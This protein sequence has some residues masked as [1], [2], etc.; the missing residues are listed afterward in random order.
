MYKYLMTEFTRE[1]HEVIHRY[2][3]EYKV[4]VAIVYGVNM[5]FFKEE[6]TIPNRMLCVQQLYLL[7]EKGS[8]GTWEIGMYS[9]GK[10]IFFSLYDSLEEA[11]WGL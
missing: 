1:E 8:E 7:E 11:L 3:D 10:Y 4:E 2:C 6:R 9:Q 5:S